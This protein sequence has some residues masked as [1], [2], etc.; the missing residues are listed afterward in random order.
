MNI[1]QTFYDNLATQY[2]KLFL[3]SITDRLAP[4]SIFMASIRDYDALLSTKPYKGIILANLSRG[5]E[6]FANRI[7]FTGR[8]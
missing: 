7:A 2:D 1:T 4:G 8:R 3:E 5:T 6:R